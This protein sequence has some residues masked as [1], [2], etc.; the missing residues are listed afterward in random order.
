M[1]LNED[2]KPTREERVES[3]KTS[4]NARLFGTDM[5]MLSD[6]PITEKQREEMLAYRQ[7]L[8]DLP[9]QE[10]FPDVPFPER[11]DFMG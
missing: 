1:E 3:M 9:Q 11:P 4:R 8:R 2:G 5:Y 6:F 10:G 7:A